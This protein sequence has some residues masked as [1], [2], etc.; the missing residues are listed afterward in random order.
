LRNLIISSL[1]GQ[2]TYQR[3]S[4]HIA[5]VGRHVHRSHY[6]ASEP[7]PTF[8][9][10]VLPQRPNPSSLRDT[11]ARQSLSRE[12]HFALQRSQTP[13]TQVQLRP[14]T[15]LSIETQLKRTAA[16]WQAHGQLSP[17]GCSNSQADLGYFSS[18][19]VQPINQRSSHSWI[20]IDPDASNRISSGSS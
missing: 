11:I 9:K 3:D 2:T 19:V 7:S 20:N 10:Q 16:L 17:K 14:E 18:C 5:L 8:N 12:L 4:Y 15:E 13:D 6:N 1:F